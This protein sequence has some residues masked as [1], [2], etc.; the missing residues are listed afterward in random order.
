M[1]GI[2]GVLFF[3]SNCLV[4]KFVIQKM[5]E[6]LTSRGPDE[7]GFYV[8]ENFGI[9]VRRL[10]II[11]VAGG[12]QPVCNEDQTIY[13]ALNGELYNYNEIKRDGLRTLHRFMSDSDTEVIPHAYEDYGEE[14]IKIINGMFG[15]ALWDV[16]QNTL[17]LYRDRLGIKPLYFYQDEH[18]FIWGSELKAILASGLVKKNINKKAV[19]LYFRFGYVPGPHSIFDGIK[20]L[21]PGHY[22]RIRDGVRSIHNYWSLETNKPQENR[23]DI[24]VEDELYHLL[25]QSVKYRLISDVPL[26]AFLSGGIDSSFIVALMNELLNRP[27]D[28]F[29][30]KFAER[31]FDESHYARRVS[32]YLGTK[33]HQYEVKPDQFELLTKIL[34]YFDEPFA[35]KSLVP[36]YYISKIAKQ[37]VTVALSGDGGDEL[38]GGYLKYR[39]LK[40]AALCNRL[41]PSLFYL[42]TIFGY[43]PL[44]IG[45]MLNN[46]IY[47]GQMTPAQRFL[48]ISEV[49]SAAQRHAILN[50][51]AIPSLKYDDLPISAHLYSEH[52][53]V[54]SIDD[55]MN[56][57]FHADLKTYLVDD[58]LT[59][60]DRMSMCHSLEV[61][62]PLLDHK[63][64]EYVLG[65]PARLKLN[66]FRGKYIFK[67]IAK[68]LLPKDIIE[69]KKHAWLVPI[70]N[71][72][73]DELK[74][75]LH[76]MLFY[77]HPTIDELLDIEQLRRLFTE[78]IKGEKDHSTILW[79]V[80]VFI[81]WLNCWYLGEGN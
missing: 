31:R 53:H 21:Q 6:T 17:L 10:A 13:A 2:C 75:P 42:F 34:P 1:C 44:R 37:H 72:L 51:H 15:I 81:T 7:V 5:T 24:E 57:W 29:T 50:R 33:H 3:D 76:A 38:F 67:N 12:K 63:V 74:E 60:V 26:G 69:R 8:N 70:G 55:E 23:K 30:I 11:D 78:H 28:T 27:I 40:G 62:V 47:Y 35:D 41:S 58:V 80:M 25:C 32:S 4:D 64:V 43:L 39:T 79:N 73:L 61:R 49:T 65:L 16:R 48:S 14:F 9:G 22:L 66:S 20:K 36:T 52:D 19:D 18:V 68:R 46:A 54:N 77:K 59:K 71:W 45:R 56:R